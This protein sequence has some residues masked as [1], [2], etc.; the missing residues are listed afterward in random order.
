MSGPGPF[1]IYPPLR[2]LMARIHGK[3]TTP[4]MMERHPWRLKGFSIPERR[5]SERGYLSLVKRGR[6]KI[7][8]RSGSRVQ[9]PPLAYRG[10]VIRP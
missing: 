10:R 3:D 8:S 2:T 9:I 4:T 6:L 7:C 1:L 5:S